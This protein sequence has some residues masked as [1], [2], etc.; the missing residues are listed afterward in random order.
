MFHHQQIENFPSVLNGRCEECTQPVAPEACSTP[1]SLNATS[2]SQ[3]HLS[4]S[5]QR[6]KER[7]S[8]LGWGTA[9]L[10]ST[11]TSLI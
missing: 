6:S 5:P 7:G 9:S 1:T 8:S 2:T 10:P 4:Y 11:C 3:L